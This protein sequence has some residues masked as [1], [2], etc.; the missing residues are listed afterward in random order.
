M[1]ICLHQL[2]ADPDAFRESEKVRFRDPELIDR[3]LEVDSRCKAQQ[4]EVD[5]LKMEASGL[6]KLIAAARKKEAKAA[7]FDSKERS[8]N[9]TVTPRKDSE[10]T[11]RNDGEATPRKECESKPI[12]PRKE[13]DSKP[14][15]PRTPRSAGESKGG[16]QGKKGK[17]RKESAA[18]KGDK[19]VDREAEGE[20]PVDA[21]KEGQ[22][23]AAPPIEGEK[24][25]A[26]KEGQHEAAPPAGNEAVEEKKPVD[27]G[28]EGQQEAAPPIEAG[29]EA[30]EE[31]GNAESKD[32]TPG[33]SGNGTVSSTAGD[34]HQKTGNNEESAG[35][36]VEY[37]ENNDGPAEKREESAEKKSGNFWVKAESDT[38]GPDDIDANEKDDAAAGKNDSAGGKHEESG[39]GMD[40]SGANLPKDESQSEVKADEK[41]NDESAVPDK[42]AEDGDNDGKPTTY[43]NEGEHKQEDK[44]SASSDLNNVVLDA[45]VPVDELLSG[46][47]VQN[48]DA[49]IG[50]ESDERPSAA[51]ARAGQ[52]ESDG[53][54]RPPTDKSDVTAAPESATPGETD[55]ERA[56]AE[57]REAEE[58]AKAA[59]PIIAEQQVLLSSIGK[60]LL[61]LSQLSETPRDEATAQ[62]QKAA[63]AQAAALSDAKTPTEQP[64][65][66]EGVTKAEK[67]NPNTGSLLLTEAEKERIVENDLGRLKVEV[68]EGD[69]DTMGEVTKH[70]AMQLQRDIGELLKNEAEMRRSRDSFIA[71]MQ[72]L[73]SIFVQQ[74]PHV[75][76]GD[77][78]VT[79][80]GRSSIKIS[81]K[82]EYEH[83]CNQGN[84]LPFLITEPECGNWCG[85]ARANEICRQQLRDQR[86]NLEGQLRDL[87]AGQP[88]GEVSKL[89]K[90]GADS[91]PGSPDGLGDLQSALLQEFHPADARDGADAHGDYGEEALQIALE[92]A[93]KTAIDQHKSKTEAILAKMAD[94]MAAKIG[95]PVGDSAVDEVSPAG[96]KVEKPPG[97]GGPGGPS[98]SSGTGLRDAAPV[99]S[100]PDEDDPD[101]DDPNL[102]ESAKFERKR[103]QIVGE[104]RAQEKILE[105][106]LEERKRL[107]CG[108]GNRVAVEGVGD[109]SVPVSNDERDNKAYRL[110]ECDRQ[111]K[112]RVVCES[113]RGFFGQQAVEAKVMDSEAE[114]EP[115][116]KKLRA[117]VEQYCAALEA[118]VA[119]S[120]TFATPRKSDGSKSPRK[121]SNRTP[122][123]DGEKSPRKEGESGSKSPRKDSASS[124]RKDSAASGT[125]P[126][127]SGS[128][129][130]KSVVD[131]VL[132]GKGL[133]S[134]W[135]IASKL[136][137][138]DSVRG[139]K[140][141]GTRGYFLRGDGARLNLALLNY[142]VS[143]LRGVFVRTANMRVEYEFLQP[144][145]W[146]KPDLMLKAAELEDAQETLYRVTGGGAAADNSGGAGSGDDTGFLIATAEQPLT[147]MFSGETFQDAKAPEKNPPPLPRVFYSWS[148]CFRR[149]VTSHGKDAKGLF[150]IHNFEKIEQFAVT[151]AADSDAVLDQFIDNAAAFYQSLGLDYRLVRIVSGKLN[152]AA[153]RKVDLEARFPGSEG[154]GSSASAETG[155]YRELCSASNCTDYQA[156]A[157]EIR[158]KIP[159]PVEEASDGTESA[160][161]SGDGVGEKKKKKSKP[162]KAQTQFCH[163]VNAT[164][165]ATQRTLCCILEN[166]QTPYGLVIPEVLRPFMGGEKLLRW[167][168]GEGGGRG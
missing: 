165:C 27:A 154:V 54:A 78:F 135:E 91:N 44:A 119:V 16:G 36:E 141:A 92:E 158:C 56:A 23:E 85:L 76:I 19:A 32:E 118:A 101:E 18:G 127:A 12:T 80:S 83:L 129:P 108:I 88:K 8:E 153:T 39:A 157:L 160:T 60:S 139:S 14:V 50:A 142:A 156:R 132:I 81:R 144:P 89:L 99:S 64:L 29:T 163:L 159:A 107:I 161:G 136:D 149:E 24:P 48:P 117:E 55:P 126:R 53:T 10:A 73:F 155:G 65:Q 146:V 98:S 42:Q 9:K 11:P 26:G 67:R 74:N 57:A 49:V 66:G 79:S 43:N 102:P 38:A 61:R 7:G 86:E 63:M 47:R 137:L 164:L 13:G 111:K 35:K 103:A 145:L 122:R 25:D 51:Q 58:A 20:K 140:V 59:A 110:W 152:L 5:N 41:V 33:A 90:A 2:R 113:L 148:S 46:D 52:E 125:T 97:G 4:S 123:K 133:L 45:E 120:V 15:T 21:G 134:H 138:M 106:L 75:I 128:T 87:V 22:H 166:Y 151:T 1:P 77:E 93:H 94:S 82:F 95:E 40:E 116:A 70:A 100:A 114:E 17:D 6:Q 147:A 69:L 68:E 115:A 28:K 62:L 124:P 150:R 105:L 104:T 130:R 96:N 131:P 168:E 30:V 112:V 3:V 37:P 167:K 84:D 34:G 162:P 72:P 109:G 121:D 71:K 143:C 31:D